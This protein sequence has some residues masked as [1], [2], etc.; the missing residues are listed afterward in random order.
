MMGKILAGIIVIT[1]LIAGAAMYYLQVYGFYDT[2]EYT[3]DH[4]KLTVLVTGTPEPMLVDGFTGIDADSSPLRFRACFTTPLSQ[5]MLTETYVTYPNP[6]PL[7]APGWFDC[8]DAGAIGAALES[9]EAIAFIGQEN[10]EYGV[11]RV[12]AVF[13]DGRA[14]VWHQLNN[15][16][17][18]RYDGT[19]VGPSCPARDKGN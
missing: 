11:D 12:I 9:G 14:Y 16:G 15:C 18:R 4:I 7:T 3:P 8:F 6:T 19:D 1:S 17:Q 5:A 10:I 2:V 13:G